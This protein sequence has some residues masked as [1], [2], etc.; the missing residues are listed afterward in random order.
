[1]VAAHNGLAIAGLP[2]VSLQQ[3]AETRRQAGGEANPWINPDLLPAGESTAPPLPRERKSFF[4]R[5]FGG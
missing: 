1:M 4:R 5:L 3:L 2:G